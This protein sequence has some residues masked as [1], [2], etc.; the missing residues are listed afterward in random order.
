MK[1]DL[2]KFIAVLTARRYAFVVEN[3]RINVTHRG[4][5]Y[6]PS[7]TTLPDGVTF[8]NGGYVC[9]PGL[10][11]GECRYRGQ[12]IRLEYIDGYTMVVRSVRVQGEYRI[13]SCR[14]FGGGEIDKLHACYVA[15]SG[16]YSA[17]GATVA[18]AIRDI[19]FK[20]AQE[21]FDADE[22]IETIRQ[23]GTIEF[24]DFRLLTGAC[25][26][27]LRHG[28]EQAGLSPETEVLPLADALRAAHG[29]YGNAFRAL[30]EGEAA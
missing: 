12:K 20:I 21:N 27:G 18:E 28:L 26:E 17:H 6:L 16:E 29:P 3:G 4:R 8:A 15:Q 14:Y 22:L 23:R 13:M 1:S 19:R 11:N 5:V 30:F 24:N 7:L 2:E 9:L 10:P 25:E